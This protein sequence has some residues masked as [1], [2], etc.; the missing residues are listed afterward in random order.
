MHK[1]KR[2]WLGAGVA[3]ELRLVTTGNDFKPDDAKASGG[4]LVAHGG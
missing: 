3:L 2:A 4:G 1:V